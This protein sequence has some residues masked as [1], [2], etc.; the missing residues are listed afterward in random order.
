MG[1]GGATLG[2]PEGTDVGLSV[3]RTS[4]VGENVVVGDDDGFM[5]GGIEGCGVGPKDG[6][7]V[8][9]SVGEDV[10]ASVGLEVGDVVG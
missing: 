9:G 7:V 4:S 1:V 10:G 5:E 6:V 2:S 8:G 3:G